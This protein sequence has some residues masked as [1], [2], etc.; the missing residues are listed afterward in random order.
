MSE[1]FCEL[2][3]LPV[4]MCVHGQPDPDV[5]RG[6]ERL[7]G[8]RYDSATRLWQPAPGDYDWAELWRIAHPDDGL[9]DWIVSQY[10]GRCRGCGGLFEPGELIRYYA[11]EDGYLA[12]C[13]GGSAP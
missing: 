8:E 6:I 1:D 4:S 10:G 3:L 9:R 5:V 12:E 2:C 13:C 7:T 11:D